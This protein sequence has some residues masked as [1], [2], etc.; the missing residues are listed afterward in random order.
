MSNLCLWLLICFVF[1]ET[2]NLFWN[3]FTISACARR[4][5]DSLKSW[6][7][8][9][10]RFEFSSASMKW[11]F[12]VLICIFSFYRGRSL[13]NRNK[14]G[15]VLSHCRNS[16]LK[17]TNTVHHNL[18]FSHF[19]NCPRSETLLGKWL[20]IAGAD[21]LSTYSSWIINKGVQHLFFSNMQT[22]TNNLL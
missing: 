8:Q 16:E 9:W 7:F 19:A 11:A 20:K 13:K 2:G 3:L 17:L 10:L 18:D 22:V 15:R 12:C 14:F 4:C 1:S 21:L 6:L 5:L